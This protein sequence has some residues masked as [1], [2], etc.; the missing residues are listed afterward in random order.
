GL[1]DPGISEVA[2][3]AMVRVELAE[4]SIRARLRRDRLGGRA[5][6]DLIVVALAVE[7]ELAPELA[8]FGRRAPGHGHSFQGPGGPIFGN[9]HL[10]PLQKWF[11]VGRAGAQQ[12]IPGPLERIH[13]SLLPQTELIGQWR[14]STRNA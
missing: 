8:A 7:A 5:D 3:A 14:R 6:D 11:D 4:D 12:N 13:R 9:G 10:G 1:P 2:A